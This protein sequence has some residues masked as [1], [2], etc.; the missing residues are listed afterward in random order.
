MEFF[1]RTLV[2][3]LFQTN[4]IFYLLAAAGVWAVLWWSIENFKSIL[5]ITKTI[6]TPY[7]QPQESKTLVERYGKWAGM[8]ESSMES[9]RKKSMTP[10]DSK[11]KLH[12]M[13]LLL[14]LRTF[15]AFL[16]VE[17]FL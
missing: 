7:F 10:A 8:K 15:N 2:N 1:L 12:A 3:F 6:L 4:L 16:I 17:E 11:M 14:D 13:H 5:L 9:D